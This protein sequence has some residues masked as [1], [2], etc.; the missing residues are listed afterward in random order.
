VRREGDGL[1]AE[2]TLTSTA[3]PNEVLVRAA[4]SVDRFDLESLAVRLVGALQLT[5]GQ[6][7]GSEVTVPAFTE[8]PAAVLPF[9]EVRS[10]PKRRA[11]R[12]RRRRPAGR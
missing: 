1:A 6:P 5:S 3:R 11:G 2:I 8:V 9:F 12:T 7:L 4:A 10:P